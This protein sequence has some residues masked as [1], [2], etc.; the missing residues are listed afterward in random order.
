[1]GTDLEKSAESTEE[2]REIKHKGGSAQGREI[3]IV[4]AGGEAV[5]AALRRDPTK[6]RSNR[7]VKPLLQ[8]S[9]AF[10]LLCES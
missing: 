1:M 6:H 10:A 7:G 2:E 8:L 5:G 4:D 3:G 9:L